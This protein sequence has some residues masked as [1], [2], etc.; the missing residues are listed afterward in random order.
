V[1][2]CIIGYQSLNAAIEEAEFKDTVEF[3]WSPFELNPDM[4]SEGKSYLDYGRDKY[5]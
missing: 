4:P 5:G 3:N 1:P 2:W